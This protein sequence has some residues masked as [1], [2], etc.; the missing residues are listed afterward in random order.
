MQDIGN[1]N[2]SKVN[3]MTGM[4]SDASSFDQVILNQR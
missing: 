4:F 1:W 3:R 2:V